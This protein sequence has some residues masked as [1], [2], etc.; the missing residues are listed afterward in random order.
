MEN[1]HSPSLLF[2]NGTWAPRREQHSLGCVTSWQH[3]WAILC[4][5]SL[6]PG[7]LGVPV[8]Q[9]LLLAGLRVLELNELL[10]LVARFAL[11][12]CAAWRGVTQAEGTLPRW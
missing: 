12:Y 11:G 3:T 8:Q 6:F 4:G 7:S 9:S 5:G 10:R 2:P 1:Y